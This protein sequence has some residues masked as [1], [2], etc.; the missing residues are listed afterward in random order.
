MWLK[1]NVLILKLST[2]KYGHQRIYRLIMHILLWRNEYLKLSSHVSWTQLSFH[3]TNITK[4]HNHIVRVDESHTKINSISIYFSGVCRLVIHSRNMI[5]MGCHKKDALDAVLWQSLCV[6]LDA[7][8]TQMNHSPKQTN[9]Q[10]EWRKK[11]HRVREREREWVCRL[12]FIFL[13][14]EKP[15]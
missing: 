6:L 11:T 5:L 15:S 8:K 14:F 3:Q 1:E 7:N 2:Q 13:E 12:G 4:H 10:T 9:K